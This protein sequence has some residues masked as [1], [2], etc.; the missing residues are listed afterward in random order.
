MRQIST[1]NGCRS[2]RS[3]D[4]GLRPSSSDTCF[5]KPTNFPLGEDQAS[6]VMLFKLTLRIVNECKRS[7]LRRKRSA[8]V[9][10]SRQRPQFVLVN[11]HDARL[12]SPPR[13]LRRQCRRQPSMGSPAITSLQLIGE[14]T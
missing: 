9:G 13:I 7:A 8:A 14:F 11:T 12:N 6:Y 3:V 1:S 10:S 2:F 4:L 5:P